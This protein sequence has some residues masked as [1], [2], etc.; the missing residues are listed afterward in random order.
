LAIV[1]AVGLVG[2]GGGAY[3]LQRG[4]ELAPPLAVSTCL[5]VSP[6]VVFAIG[7]F[8]SAAGS[9]P[10]IFALVSLIVAV[11]L[12]AIVYDGNRLRHPPAAVT[13]SPAERS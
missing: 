9:D 10:T 13:P 4:V 3:L 6:V 12:T 2:V 8:D 11:S 7:I 5:A 1:A